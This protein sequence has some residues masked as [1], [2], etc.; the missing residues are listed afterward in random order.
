[1]PLDE[2]KTV[3]DQGVKFK[4]IKKPVDL[5]TL[6]TNDLVGDINSFDPNSVGA[7]ASSGG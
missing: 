7:T 2:Y 5:G 6:L 1:M 4:I 3:Q